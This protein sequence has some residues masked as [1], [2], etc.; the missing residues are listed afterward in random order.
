MY[1]SREIRWFSNNLNEQI[2]KWF[3]KYQL[4]FDTITPRLDF[5]LPL[6]N[7]NIGIKL[8]EGNIEIKHRLGPPHLIALQ[9]TCEGYLEDWIKWSFEGDAS[10]PLLEEITGQEKYEWSKIYKERLGVK[11]FKEDESLRIVPIETYISRG[12]QVEY[13]RAHINGQTWFTFGLEWF[14]GA[15]GE[16]GPSLISEMLKNIAL[17]SQQSMGYPAFL[18]QEN[19]SK[20]TWPE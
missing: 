2:C 13:T 15:Y 9:E 6:Q 18:N 8:R 10:D 20:K 12:C 1:R 3:Q 5:Y 7:E 17:S 4:E 11:L 14:G 16:L 19:Y